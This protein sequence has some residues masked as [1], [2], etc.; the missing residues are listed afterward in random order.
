MVMRLMSSICMPQL[1]PSV[2]RG[3]LAEMVFCVGEMMIGMSCCLPEYR[4]FSEVWICCVRGG[5]WEWN[6]S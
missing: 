3:V 2:W 4:C 1:H 6:G 5:G